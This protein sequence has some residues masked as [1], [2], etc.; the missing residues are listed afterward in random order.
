[1]D[2]Y[3]FEKIDARMAAMAAVFPPEVDLI[4]IGIYDGEELLPG[5]HILDKSYVVY[6]EV[7]NPDLNFEAVQ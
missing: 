3:D 6:A 4:P 2:K 5:C 7:P 1:M